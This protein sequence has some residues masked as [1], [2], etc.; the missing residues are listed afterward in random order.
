VKTLIIHFV[1]GKLLS[2]SMPAET[3]DKTISGMNIYPDGTTLV[4]SDN[5][6]SYLIFRAQVTHVTVEP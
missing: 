2:L 6:N 5:G 4:T 3:A 1:S